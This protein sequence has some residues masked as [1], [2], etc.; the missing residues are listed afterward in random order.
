[1][2]VE[3]KQQARQEVRAAVIYGAEHF[4]ERTAIS[5]YRQIRIQAELLASHPKLGI[6]EPLLSDRKHQYRSLIVHKHHKLVYYI[7]EQKDT[8][9]IAD[10]WDMRRE[11]S[12]LSNRLG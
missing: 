6:L 1:M 11:P 12:R 10:L 7:D 3:W 2:Q 5:F 8:I 4:G 9:Y